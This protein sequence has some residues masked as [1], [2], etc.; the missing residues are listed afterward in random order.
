MVLVR[1]RNRQEDEN[2]SNDP[3]FGGEEELE[4]SEGG[5]IEKENTSKSRD[6]PFTPLWTVEICDKTQG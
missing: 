4:G 3:L 6:D 2:I 1:N 5:E